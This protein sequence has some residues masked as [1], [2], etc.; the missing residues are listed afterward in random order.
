[1][2]TYKDTAKKT[3][4]AVGEQIALWTRTPQ[5]PGSRPGGYGSFSTELLT[6]YHYI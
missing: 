1:M 2:A 3:E 5:V 4:V 6:D